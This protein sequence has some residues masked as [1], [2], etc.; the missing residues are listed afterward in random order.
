MSLYSEASKW[1]RNLVEDNQN[2]YNRLRL[3]E[4]QRKILESKRSKQ[5]QITVT[6]TRVKSSR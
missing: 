1:S 2:E 5:Q 6:S 3:I 4:K